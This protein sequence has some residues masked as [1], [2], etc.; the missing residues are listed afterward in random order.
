MGGDHKYS[1]SFSSASSSLFSSV[2][3]ICS[4]GFKF[5]VSELWTCVSASNL[6]HTLAHWVNLSTTQLE[7]SA[8]RPVPKQIFILRPPSCSRLGVS[9]SLPCL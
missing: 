8:P 5:S 6:T 7:T 2:G 1:L 4:Q 9:H 3:D